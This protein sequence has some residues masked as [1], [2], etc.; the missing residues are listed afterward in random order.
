MKLNK[1]GLGSSLT[2]MAAFALG[3]SG[4]GAE[5]DGEGGAPN[6][7]G[8]SIRVQI[9]GEELG[10]SGFR[11]PTGSEVTIADGWELR[12]DHVLVSVG[13]VWLSE[14][15]D[16]NPSDQSQLGK[17]VA[18]KE[19]P[20][21]VDLAQEGEAEAA[22]GEG[23]AIPL[24]TFDS[25]SENGGKPFAT[26]ERYGFSYSFTA[27][28]SEAQL[29]NLS[30]D[31]ADEA[32]AQMVE[33]GYAVYYVGTARFRGTECSV[34][35]DY[36]FDAIPTTVPFALG[37]KTPAEFLNCQNEENDGDAFSGEEFQRGVA[38][39][40]SQ[41]AVAQLTIHLDHLVYSD[42]E[43]EPTLYFDQFAAQLVGKSSDTVLTTDLLL[44]LDPTAMTDGEG[45]PLPWRRCDDG[46]L[47]KSDPRAFE[48]GTIAVGASLDPT[49]GFRD[50]ADFVNYV[51]SSQG[52][53]NGGEGLCF[54]SRKF[55]APN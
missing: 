41:A 11:F 20:W 6:D 35:G 21:I 23:T 17:T 43:H 42:V 12:F 16:K 45:T 28:S 52:H 25:Q 18:V 39:L 40:P 46:D 31:S 26:D 47:P 44:G 34:S 5:S 14:T 30:G 27:P 50:Y 8:G 37:F 19:G 4:K 36:D 24:F 7:E 2:L 13:K 54:T 33:E 15:P 3:C 32:F 22:G 49:E 51:Q 9:S 1:L 48:T 38:V 53:L 10:P 29:M 55:D